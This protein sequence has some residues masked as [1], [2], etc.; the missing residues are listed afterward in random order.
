MNLNSESNVMGTQF[1][2]SDSTHYGSRL[3]LDTLM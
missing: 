2:D 3:G 1:I